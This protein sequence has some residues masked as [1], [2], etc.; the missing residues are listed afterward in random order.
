MRVLMTRQQR[1]KQFQPFDAM[2][3]L[4]EAL[5]DREER[6]NRSLKR[7][8]SEEKIKDIETILLR[9]NKGTNIRIE[10]YKAFH[11]VVIR[12]IVDKIDKVK[13]LMLVGEEKIFFDDIYEI[14][15]LDY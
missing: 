2:K 10:Y 1:A 8:I 12:G 7:E 13:C 6:H 3:G 4:S 9:V 11:Y 5:R 15:I 14:R